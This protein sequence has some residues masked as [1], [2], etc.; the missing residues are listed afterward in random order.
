MWKIIMQ[1]S[2]R[3]DEK[4]GVLDI[5]HG[6]EVKTHANYI[7][8]IFIFYRIS[9]MLH[10]YGHS[11]L[12]YKWSNWFLQ[13]SVHRQLSYV[14]E[15][16]RSCVQDGIRYPTDKDIATRMGITIEQ[17]QKL[18]NYS[19]HIIVLTHRQMV[20]LKRNFA[21]VYY[22]FRVI[23]TLVPKVLLYLDLCAQSFY[24]FRSWCPLDPFYL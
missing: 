20:C 16:K 18:Y 17:L 24:I 22:K 9:M 5:F 6:K 13:G 3:K 4:Y 19:P 2:T 15:A 14:E 7:W 8:D 11:L 1:S 23:C 12:I 10:T 21:S